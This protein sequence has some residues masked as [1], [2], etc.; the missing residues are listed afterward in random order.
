VPQVIS[1]QDQ[2]NAYVT[3]AQ[4]NIVG[5]VAQVNTVTDVVNTQT[6]VSQDAALPGASQIP[7]VPPY[8]PPVGQRQ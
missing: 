5:I 2:T 8:Q 3:D 1:K 6:Q 7:V 4:A